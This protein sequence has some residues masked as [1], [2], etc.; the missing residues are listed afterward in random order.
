MKV[1]KRTLFIVL[2]MLLVEV[3]SGQEW[4][5]W[6]QIEIKGKATDNL[7]WKLVSECRVTGAD[8]EL[9]QGWLEARLDWKA[10]P[11]LILSPYYRITRNLKG[12]IWQSEYR[13]ILAATLS[14]GLRGVQVDIRNRIEYRIFENTNASRYRARITTK[15]PQFSSLNLRPYLGDEIFYDMELERLNKNWVIM[16]LHYTAK[17]R[18]KLEFNY[19]FQNSLKNEEWL[20]QNILRTQLKITL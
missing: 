16:G 19:M 12:N 8:A 4:E 13:P 1:H 20:K 3:V 18:F 11:W 17:S 15:L 2:L 7:T 5:L 14:Q 10:M 9:Y 6:P